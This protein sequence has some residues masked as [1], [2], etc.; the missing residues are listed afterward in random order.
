MKKLVYYY[1]HDNIK[2]HSKYISSKTMRREANGAGKVDI[3][4]CDEYHLE[5]MLNG[6]LTG[7]YIT[8]KLLK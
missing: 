4:E 1:S 2:I 5:N 3:Y 8:T 6:N 7:K